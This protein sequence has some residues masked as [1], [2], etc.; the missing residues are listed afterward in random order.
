MLTRMFIARY[1]ITTNPKCLFIESS[2]FD[3]FNLSTIII[4]DL[5]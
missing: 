4:L 3:K 2:S 5:E 1:V